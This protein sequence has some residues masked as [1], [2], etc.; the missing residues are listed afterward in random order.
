MWEVMDQM[1]GLRSQWE[2][3]KGGEGTSELVW[4]R[5]LVSFG[6]SQVS[7]NKHGHKVQMSEAAAC[8]KWTTFILAAVGTPQSE[9]IN[10]VGPSES[11]LIRR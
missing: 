1:D 2:G 5:H 10:K 11:F 4:T 8:R 3:A 6:Q 9:S 7:G